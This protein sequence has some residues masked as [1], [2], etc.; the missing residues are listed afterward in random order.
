VAKQGRLGKLLASLRRLPHNVK[1]G[2]LAYERS[3]KKGVEKYGVWWKVFQWS[4]WLFILV[5]IGTA[6]V[7]FVF[8]L[9]KLE[10]IKYI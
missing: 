3:Y 9:P 10:V 2:I 7:A 1:E 6:V 5:F 4:M 8:Y